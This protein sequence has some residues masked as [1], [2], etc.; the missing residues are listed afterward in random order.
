[1]S[2]PSIERITL[3]RTLAAAIADVWDLWTTGPGLEAWWGPDGFAVTVRSLDLRP[4]GA[5]R[6]AMTAVEPDKVAF[7]KAHGMPVTQEVSVTFTAVE[8]RRR[9]A[10]VNLV[11][12][13]PGVAPYDSAVEV[14]FEPVAGGVRLTV[15]VDRMHDETWTQRAAMGWGQQLGRLEAT[16][17]GRAGAR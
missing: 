7:M 2:T 5:L 14:L 3:E 6:Y 9:L 15:L 1:M 12:F 16:L 11:D 4:G 8:P 10:F 17:R 13:V